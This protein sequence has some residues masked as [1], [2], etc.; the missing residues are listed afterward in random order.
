[1]DGNGWIQ[2]TIVSTTVGKNFIWEIE[3]PSQSTKESKMSYLSAISKMTEWS[4]FIFIQHHSNPNLCLNHWCQRQWSW[5]VLRRPTGPSNTKRDVLF[6]TG[7]WN[8]KVG[9]EGIPWVIG[10]FVLEV[11]NEA[12][13]RLTAL[14]REHT[15]HSKHPF[16]IIQETIL[17][18]DITKGQYQ[19]KTDIFFVAV[20][21]KALY[22]Q[23]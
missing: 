21:G 18:M 2:M 12:G 4:R 20:D 15:G 14:S 13:K 19:N 5:P 22:S 7:N 1:M 9:H 6:I 11:Q 3:Q 23:F 8:A 17:H 16:P 10:K